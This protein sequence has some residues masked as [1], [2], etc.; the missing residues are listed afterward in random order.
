MDYG[1]HRSQMRKRAPHPVARADMRAVQGAGFTRKEVLGKIIGIP[2]VEIP[3]LRPLDAC[4]SKDL[5][6][7]GAKQPRLAGRN[8]HLIDLAQ[9][10]P[11]GVKPHLIRARQ[12]VGRIAD[13]RGDC[14]AGTGVC[15]RFRLG[16]LRSPLAVGLWPIR[17]N[18]QVPALSTAKA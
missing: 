3:D 16:H 11:Q 5:P 8:E 6:S 12:R 9:I 13:H 2:K 7:L 4:N 10:C 17:S 1:R 15:W 14:A 18:R